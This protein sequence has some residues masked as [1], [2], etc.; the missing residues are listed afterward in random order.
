MKAMGFAIA[1]LAL[2]ACTQ[3]STP[4]NPDENPPV[5]TVKLPYPEGIEGL[6]DAVPTATLHAKDGDTVRMTVTFVAKW[7]AGRKVRMLA[8]NGSVPGPII[9]VPQGAEITL[10]LKNE[11]KL[12]TT[13]HSHGVRLDY[14]SDGVPGIGRPPVDSGDVFAYSIRF[15]DPGIYWYHPH[16]REDYQME[17]GLYGSYLVAPEDTT[18]WPPVHREVVL[19]LD[20]IAMRGNGIQPFYSNL[21][22]H[23]LMGRFGNVFLTN[24][25]TAFTT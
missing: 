17:L 19:M 4:V 6:P 3:K 11:T 21:P 25:D 9:K 10:L 23:S 5:N 1:I 13:L 15:P 14:R 7:I 16:Q 8:Y 20:D 12:P 24:G 22:D 18:Y 2:S